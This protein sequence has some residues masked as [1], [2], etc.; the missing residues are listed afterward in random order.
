M[1]TTRTTLCICCLTLATVGGLASR[2]NAALVITEVLSATSH[3]GGAANGDWWELLNTGESTVNLLG[4]FW[5]D[6]NKLTGTRRVFPGVSIAPNE[7][8]LVVD[9][10]SA[11]IV[12]FKSAWG[13]AAEMQVLSSNDITGG[14]AGL[15][16]NG[17]EVNLYS[18]SE[19]LVASVAFGTATTGS[20]FAWDR[21]GNSLGISAAGQNGAYVAL[22]NGAAGAGSD[23]ASPGYV[24][25]EPA[26]WLMLAT[27]AV[28][29][30]LA[31]IRRR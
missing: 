3:P 7:I 25:P 26:T 21:N 27:A 30:A 1:K 28:M 31:T 5:N 8:I 6:D 24:V 23:I 14:F 10:P 17:D 18:P 19:S 11:N 16:A 12:S 13:L 29:A 15:G 9:E 4:Y 22:N 2:A 20:T